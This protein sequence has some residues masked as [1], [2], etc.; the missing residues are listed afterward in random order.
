[1]KHSKTG[2]LC[3]AIRE[4]WDAMWGPV[5]RPHGIDGTEK[6]DTVLTG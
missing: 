4:H 6:R 3:H 1:M 5:S 2:L